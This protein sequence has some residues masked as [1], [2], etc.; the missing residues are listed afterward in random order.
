MRQSILPAGPLMSC[1]I[2]GRRVTIPEPLG[3]KS[4]K[5]VKQFELDTINVLTK[6]VTIKPMSTI[7]SQQAQAFFASGLTIDKLNHLNRFKHVRAFALKALNSRLTVCKIRSL[8]SHCVLGFC[9][10][11]HKMSQ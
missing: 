6:S 10:P 5:C 9:L 2:K 7:S 1:K 11:H 4:L 8:F 3:K